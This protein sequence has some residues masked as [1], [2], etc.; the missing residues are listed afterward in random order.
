M[1]TLSIV[2]CGAPL[3][4][5][6]VSLVRAAERLGFDVSLVATESSRGWLDEGAQALVVPAPRRPEA[7]LVCPLTF[8]TGN[9]WAAGVSDNSQLGLLNESLGT[10][11]RVVAVP[12]VNESLWRHPAWA[13]SLATLANSGVMFVDPSTGD[14]EAR[15]TRHGTGDEVTAAFRPEWALD[16]LA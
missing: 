11:A 8:N 2:V 16:L 15:P 4:S 10:V 1:A 6:A 9:K 12:F 14:A 7:V 13:N 5:V 3:A